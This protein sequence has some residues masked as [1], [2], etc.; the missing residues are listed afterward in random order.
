MLFLVSCSIFINL[1]FT[2][3]VPSSLRQYTHCLHYA[4]CKNQK[5]LLPSELEPVPSPAIS[6]SSATRHIDFHLL[7][8]I[9]VALVW[10]TRLTIPQA[11]GQS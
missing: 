1:L 5:L 10:R 3:I 4:K 6:F 8:R 2:K 9:Y 7:H 11:N